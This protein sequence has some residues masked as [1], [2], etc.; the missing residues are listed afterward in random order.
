MNFFKVEQRDLRTAERNG[1][2]MYLV[3]VA[4]V[5]IDI[6]MDV[7]ISMIKEVED[8]DMMRYWNSRLLRK[9]DENR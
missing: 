1:V 3:A 7:M 2:K 4:D 5:K 9:R 6:K 8:E